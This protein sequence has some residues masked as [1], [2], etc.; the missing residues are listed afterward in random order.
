MH[1]M[2]IDFIILKPPN[3][4]PCISSFKHVFTP[5]LIQN[6]YKYMFEQKTYTDIHMVYSESIFDWE[7]RT[8]H[9]NS[10]SAILESRS[11][12]NMQFMWLKKIMNQFLPVPSNEYQYLASSRLILS[13]FRYF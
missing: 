3:T 9:S 6:I 4:H 10:I 2:Y 8:C 11:D 13:N 7:E 5:L 1:N 12:L